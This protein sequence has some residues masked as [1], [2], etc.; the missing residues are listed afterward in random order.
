MLE[1]SFDGD[2][3][4]ANLDHSKRKRESVEYQQFMNLYMWEKV[5]IY[6]QFKLYEIR[7]DFELFFITS[8][9][10]LAPKHPFMDAHVIWSISKMRLE[11]LLTDAHYHPKYYR[12][13]I[14]NLANRPQLPLMKGCK[15]SN[16]GYDLTPPDEKAEQIKKTNRALAKSV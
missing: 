13:K 7:L 1:L 2:Q 8:I 6:Q 12:R 16:G 5:R 14:G 9:I 11:R 10:P 4:V 15:A 3:K